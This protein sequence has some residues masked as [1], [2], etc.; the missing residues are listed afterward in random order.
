M[1]QLNTPI[2][3]AGGELDVY[4]AL[5]SAA[6]LVLLGGVIW[7]ALANSEHSKADANDSGG[8]FKLVDPS[9]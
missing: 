4:T 2:R 9:R 1:S 6:V 3:R 5:L 7:I 8:P